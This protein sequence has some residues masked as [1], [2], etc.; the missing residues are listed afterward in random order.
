VRA[1]S[2]DKGEGSLTGA[3]E[4]SLTGAQGEGFPAGT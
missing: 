2:Q 3:W 1:H 4:G